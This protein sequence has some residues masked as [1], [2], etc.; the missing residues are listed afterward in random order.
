MTNIGDFKG[1]A[2]DK[3][4]SLI[5]EPFPDA[6]PEL[7]QFFGGPSGML[8]RN[9]VVWFESYW[10]E[11]GPRTSE[12]DIW[13]ALQRTPERQK[14]AKRRPVVR[15]EVVKVHG[16][17]AVVYRDLRTGRFVRRRGRR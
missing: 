12:R 15:R 9:Q 5:G 1:E 8:T 3:I 7:E 2:R 17:K 11:N 10:H 13:E 6:L 14:F 16:H 4:D